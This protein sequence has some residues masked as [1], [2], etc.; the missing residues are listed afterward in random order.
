VTTAS[1]LAFTADVPAIPWP[2]TGY[3]PDLE[4]VEALAAILRCLRA[5]SIVFTAPA[6][7]YKACI[8]LPHTQR[9]SVCV[10]EPKKRSSRM[11]L[12]RSDTETLN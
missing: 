2:A 3:D 5:S 4:A 9:C 1:Q 6:V 12:L 8:T 7:S 10:S 11:Q